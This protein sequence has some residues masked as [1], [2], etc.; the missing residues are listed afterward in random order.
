MFFGLAHN[1][2][3]GSRGD[4]WGGRGG[5]CSNNDG[6][7]EFAVHRNGALVPSRSLQTTQPVRTEL[8]VE[9][10][11]SATMAKQAKGN[12]WLRAALIGVAGWLALGGAAR[13]DSSPSTQPAAPTAGAS[14]AG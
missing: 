11:R 10:G 3:R 4:G 1:V 7:R 12:A 5:I 14:A 6:G 8:S 2:A 13:A 9:R